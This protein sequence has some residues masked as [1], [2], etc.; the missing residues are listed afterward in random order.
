MQVLAQTQQ[1]GLIGSVPGK[2]FVNC[3]GLCPGER[4]CSFSC[5]VCLSESQRN[6]CVLL[7]FG[8]QM[9]A[10][11]P[12]RCPPVLGTVQLGKQGLPPLP[13]VLPVSSL[14]E[15]LDC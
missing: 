8:T 1:G 15:G 4:A 11:G 13:W 9:R 12:G 5:P 14:Y 10:P 3:R 6:L 2:G 7:R